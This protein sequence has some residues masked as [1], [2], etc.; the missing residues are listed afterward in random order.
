MPQ[1]IYL[2]NATVKDNLL[3][4]E[5][6][7]T[8]EQIVAA[9]RLALIHDFIESLPLGY[10]TLV[11]ENGFLLSGGERQRLAIARVILKNAPIVILDEPTA[12]LDSTTE[13]KLFESLAPFLKNRTTLII[14]HRPIAAEFA[15]Q[16]IRMEKGRIAEQLSSQ[17]HMMA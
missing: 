13:R 14:S 8:D 16:V 12:N 4:A 15:D 3:L 7:A 2:F 6:N 9:C 1:E 17:Q 10:D 5:A 11:G